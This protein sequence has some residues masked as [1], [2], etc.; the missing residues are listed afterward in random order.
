[1]KVISI[2]TDSK[3]FKEGSAVRQRI[4]EYGKL[5]EKLDIV[6]FSKRDTENELRVTKIAENVFV[7]PTNSRNKLFYV[8]DAFLII[9]KLIENYKL[10]I[11]NSGN[12]V[13]TSQDPFE[14]GIIGLIIKFF[15]KLPF[16]VQ[17]HT[18]FM[19]RYF[20]THSVL[21]FIRFP[22][23]L[24]VLSFADSVRCVSERVAKSIH[25]LSHNI[26]VLPV[27]TELKEREVETGEDS[28]KITFL[29][30]ARLEKEKDLG[31]AIK[32]FKQAVDNGVEAEF[33]IVGDGSQR[34][35]LEALAK[36]LELGDEVKFV[37]WQKNLEEFYGRAH[38]YLSTSLYEGYGMSMVEA[39]QYGLPLVISDAG[40]AGELFF[41]KQEAFVLKPK[42][43]R[44]FIEAMIQLA[45]NADL[46]D[47]MGSKAKVA[48]QNS[49]VSGE[50]YLERYQNSVYQAKAH[51]AQNLNIFK[52]NIL[53]RYLVAGFTGA[54]TNIGL[55]YI[56]T[57][58]V[59][60]WYLYSSAM[61]FVVA[62]VVSFML[63]KFW[64][65][66][67]QNVEKVHHQFARF[68]GVALFGIII[69]TACM[70]FL[71][72]VIGLWYILAQIITGALIAII[73]FLMYKFLI[74][75]K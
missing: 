26:S 29:T 66:A 45:E 15:Y 39:A 41:D 63:Q 8:W 73:N 19:N 3:I 46:R 54:G 57:D 58:I 59:G 30:V 36:S 55:L 43:I 28:K 6:V 75:N 52:K 25:T 60:I 62:V 1:M 74:F 12:V 16:Q 5:F 17:V 64:T 32:A 67:D 4:V 7:Y 34:R 9:R 47:I 42:N 31:T 49:L 2:S 61:S 38:I 21:N 44:G 71:V 11:E 70:F 72:D 23:G 40:V 69:N 27:Q 50:K 24:F 56:L 22:L 20:I 13:I 10:K 51:H 65:F 14:T 68:L 37:G 48:A 18:D 35:S 33:V 53:A